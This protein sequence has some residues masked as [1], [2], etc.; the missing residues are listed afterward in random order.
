MDARDRLIV[1]LDVPTAERAT[2]LVERLG[3]AILWYKVGLELFVAEGPGVVRALT[4]RGKR[5]FLD[6]KLHDIPNTVAGAVRSA[7]RLGA[8]LLTVH[9]EG[10]PAM[11]RA[12]VSARDE[13]PESG[14]GLL[15]VTVLTSLDGTEYPEVYRNADTRARVEVFARS[16]REAG[17][18]GVVAS[19]LEL[20]LLTAA[21]PA[22]FLKVIP[23]I[24]PAG[25]AAGDQARTATPA[26]A[27]RG[28]ASHLVV[29]R[30]I[31]GAADPVAAAREVLREMEGAG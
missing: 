13:A 30:A 3:D 4:G 12:A 17:M 31:T 14:L 18:D 25:T 10:G 28:G 24:R 21:F 19:A 9:A 6:L 16:A 27:L 23:G 22:E 5:V 15:G 26:D 7:S 2:A 29:G 8:G 11:L 20:D 1:A